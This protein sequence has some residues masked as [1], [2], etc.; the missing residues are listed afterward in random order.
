MQTKQEEKH[1]SGFLSSQVVPSTGAQV[2]FWTLTDP[3]G[4]NLLATFSIR[5]EGDETWT[6]LALDSR[7]TYVQFDTS[8]LRDG[9]YFTRL[10]AREAAPRPA[11]DRLSVTFETDNLVVDHTPPAILDASVRRTATAVV[12]TVHGRDGLSLLEGVAFKFNNGSREEV[13]QPV[14]GI[15][16]GREESF[17]LEEPVSG[18]VGATA[19]EV[20]LYDAAGNTTARTLPLPK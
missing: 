18:T 2:A 11:A 7:E 15:R 9:V 16:D 14:D 3:D 1:K 20:T 4:D 6:D 8:H 13:E 19:V 10:V 17:A 12:V 5:R